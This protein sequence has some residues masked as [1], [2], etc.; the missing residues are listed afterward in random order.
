MGAKRLSKPSNHRT[1]SYKLSG[2]AFGPGL[3]AA[4]AAVAGCLLWACGGG[5]QAQPAGA[6]GSS[7]ASSSGS[8]SS[9]SSGGGTAGGDGGSAPDCTLA[10][11]GPD[12]LSALERH[13]RD[14]MV[15]AHFE[16][17]IDFGPA[18][19]E[20]CP[21][22]AYCKKTKTAFMPNVDMAL[23]AFEEGCE[24]AMASVMLSRDFPGGRVNTIDKTTLDIQG[25]RFRRWD[26]ARWDGGT[27]DSNGIQLTTKGWTSDPPL[28]DGDD[29]VPGLSGADYFIPYPASTFKVLV[30]VKILEQYDQ[31]ALS[32]DADYTHNSVTRTLRKWMEEMIVHSDN[33]STRAL[34]KKL[35]EL[36]QAGAL[37]TL[38]AGLGLATLQINGTSA[39]TGGNWNPGQIHMGAWDTARLLWLLDSAAPAPS[40]TVSGT[41]NKVNTEFLKAGSKQ[42]LY[43]FLADQGWHEVLSTTA[44]CG[45]EKTQAGIPA[46]LPSRWIAPD[47]SVNIAGIPLSGNVKPCN[48]NAELSFAHKTGLTLNF[49]SAAGIV[50]GLS[51][52]AKRHYIISF[53]SNL[54]YRYTDADKTSGPNPCYG[55]GICYTQRIPAMALAL[56]NALKAVLEQ[57]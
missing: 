17:T 14:A 43:D 4:A 57:P 32:I 5:S 21:N 7:A 30:A 12:G 19:N 25:V 49:G 15:A 24:P 18:A 26:Q 8:A 6:G 31:G 16:E 53:F 39:Q 29:I 11:I 3:W 45:I 20:S 9:S 22:A 46:L 23:I 41:N 38:F 1:I 35:H 34:L 10:S 44:L 28:G 13:L 47:G 48:A 56:D 33:E 42:I 52:K 37:N 50:N 54:G 51:G 55:L 36:G 27:F 40:W 2:F